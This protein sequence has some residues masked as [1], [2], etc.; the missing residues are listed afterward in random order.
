MSTFYF[1][2]IY[3]RSTFSH[4]ADAF[5]QMRKNCM[6]F[7]ILYVGIKI[8]LWRTI[9]RSREN[10][11]RHQFTFH[12]RSDRRFGSHGRS[13]RPQPHY[14]PRARDYRSLTK[15]SF[16]LRFIVWLLFCHPQL[17]IIPLPGALH[18]PLLAVLSEQLRRRQSGET[19]HTLLWKRVIYLSNVKQ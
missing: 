16:L 13:F 3:R 2:W 17:P 6:Q 8:D 15:L 5:I 10:S 12:Q 19:E 1:R 18:K 7:I 4:L 14:Q 11:P 9:A